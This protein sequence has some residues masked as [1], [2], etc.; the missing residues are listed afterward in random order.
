M[1]IIPVLLVFLFL[2]C[3]TF[4]P[5]GERIHVNLNAHQL[6]VGTVEAVFDSFSRTGTRAGE[7]QVSY[8]PDNNVIC[9]EFRHEFTTFFQFWTEANRHAFVNALEQYKLDF[10]QRNLSR[11][12]NRTR[13]IYGSVN[14]YVIW[15]TT[16]VSGQAFSY[17]VIDLGYR[18]KNNAPYF[19]ITMRQAL[20]ESDYTKDLMESNSIINVY[21]TRALADDLAALFDEGFLR[22]LR[23]ERPGASRR[24]G[25]V[26]GEEY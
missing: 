3:N 24:D 8:F 22:S 9:L 18:F 12:D 26:A 20:N 21:F 23:V 11:S 5:A 19:S 15:R 17:P 10:E 2:G 1:K 25:E 13:R 16:R 6:P 14:G 7:L 4:E